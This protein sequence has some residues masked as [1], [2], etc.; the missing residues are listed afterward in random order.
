MKA[1]R[2]LLGV[3]LA[4]GLMAA[5]VATHAAAARKP[6]AIVWTT[7]KAG[8]ARAKKEDKPTMIHFTTDWC[9]WCRKLEKEV[10]TVPEVIELSQKFVC[11]RV[12]GDREKDVVQYY[13][14]RGYPTILFTNSKRE[15]VHRIPGYMPAEGFLSQMKTALG[16][17]GV[18]EETDKEDNA[19]K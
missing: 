15:E 17:A 4:A 8:M 14:V 3:V 6:T 9:G 12:D 16:K 2:M 1:L 11:I 13:K 19:E 7:F 10:Y 18:K 5:D